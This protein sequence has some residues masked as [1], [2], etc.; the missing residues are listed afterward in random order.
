[1]KITRI[2]LG[3]AILA[4][5]GLIVGCGKKEPNVAPEPDTEVQS[6]LDAAWATYVVSDIDMMCSFVGVNQPLSHFYTPIPGTENSLA[7]GTG[8]LRV[9]RDVSQKRL[10]MVFNQTQ[11]L[12]GR[13]RSGEVRLVYDPALKI[14]PKSNPNAEYYHEYGFGGRLTTT[15][16]Q[17]DGWEISMPEPGY[18]YCDLDRNDW[19]P[20]ETKV[21]WTIVGKFIFK[22]GVDS[23]KGILAPTEI[24]W[25]GKLTKVLLN[26][27]DEDVFR[28]GGTAPAVTWSLANCGYYG[29]VSGRTNSVVPFSMSITEPNML[30]RDFTCSPDRI[31]GVTLN[32]SNDMVQRD[33]EHHPFV[34]GVA[35]FTTGDKYPRQIYFGNEGN[36][37]LQAQCDNVGEVMI[38]GIAYRVNFRK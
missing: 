7:P 30:V 27:D 34:Q 37:K 35:R 15:N 38:K 22:H 8:T 21:S 2:T 17:V 23:A 14:H 5:V 3:F 1:M 10:S 24:F 16:Y 6:A 19:I 9:V 20:E 11:C 13:L 12:D 31:G 29:E 4:A 25:D 32:N 33:E 18:I 28:K 36:P 26:T